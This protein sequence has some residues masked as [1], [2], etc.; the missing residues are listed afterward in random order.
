MPVAA[1]G[2]DCDGALP[3]TPGAKC[4]VDSYCNLA[5]A[6]GTTGICTAWGAE[7]DDC[8]HE[9]ATNQ[10]CLLGSECV[11]GKCTRIGNNEV[12]D[13]QCG[14]MANDGCVTN[15]CVARLDVGADCVNGNEC[16]RDLSCDPAS[17]KCVLTTEL[18][19]E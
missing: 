15:V 4:N 18:I 19:C 3:S 10:G 7:G 5:G 8:G 11:A 9:A 2:F 16:M 17:G 13:T 6:V 1:T 14:D 12:C